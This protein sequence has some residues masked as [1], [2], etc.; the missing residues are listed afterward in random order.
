MGVG[1][2]NRP[3]DGPQLPPPSCACTPGAAVF[4][5]GDQEVVDPEVTAGRYP[6][7]MTEIERAP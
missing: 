5:A 7:A 1:T 2:R 4:V 6:H 3:S